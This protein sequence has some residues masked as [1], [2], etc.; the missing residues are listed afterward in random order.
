M[1]TLT[2]SDLEMAWGPKSRFVVNLEIG[3]VAVWKFQSFRLRYR[4]LSAPGSWQDGGTPTDFEGNW[5]Q[6]Q[7][8]GLVEGDD[9][10]FEL[11]VTEVSGVV[12]VTELVANIGFA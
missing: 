2:A 12:T 7:L 4:L 5:L 11:T 3:R 8:E 10:V 9:Y 6:W 1:V